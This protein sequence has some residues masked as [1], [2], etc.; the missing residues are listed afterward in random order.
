M[1]PKKTQIKDIMQPQVKTI[2]AKTP[3]EKAAQMMYEQKVSSLIIEPADERD[4]FGI[5]TR[6]DVIEALII[7]RMLE[8]PQLVEDVMSKPAI[9]ASGNLSIENCMK[10]MRMAGTRR[11]PVVDGTKL[12]GIISNTDIFISYFRKS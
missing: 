3:I 10:L 8:F 9:T 12:T 11:L 4:T 2:S 7:D 5:L 6:K 1:N